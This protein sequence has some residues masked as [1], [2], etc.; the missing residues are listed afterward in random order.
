M[1]PGQTHRMDYKSQE[2]KSLEC[3]PTGMLWINKALLQK[4]WAD[5]T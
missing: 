3:E 5:F 4:Q 1:N 2:S